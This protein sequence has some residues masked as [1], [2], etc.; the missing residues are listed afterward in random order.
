MDNIS[1]EQQAR[2]GDRSLLQR[3]PDSEPVPR[4]GHDPSPFMAERRK[5]ARMP[6]WYLARKQDPLHLI[7]L[8]MRA[9]EPT[10]REPCLSL[11]PLRQ[12]APAGHGGRQLADSGEPCACSKAAPSLL[13]PGRPATAMSSA[14]R[15]SGPKRSNGWLLPILPP[16]PPA[17]FVEAARERVSHGCMAPFKTPG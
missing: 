16:W 10:A 4:W 13:L 1:P 2:I 17:L 11:K 3:S 12:G 9:G 14:A 15:P 5:R 8:D 6:R 7:Q